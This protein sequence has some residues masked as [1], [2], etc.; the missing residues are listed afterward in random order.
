MI[1]GCSESQMLGTA[2]NTTYCIGRH[3]HGL[4]QAS[5][6]PRTGCAAHAPFGTAHHSRTFAACRLT[7]N[8]N[9]SMR[10]GCRGKSGQGWPFWSPQLGAI[11][12]N[13]DSGN[14]AIRDDRTVNRQ[15]RDGRSGLHNLGALPANAIRERRDQRR[16]Q[17]RR[18]N[19]VA[20][21]GTLPPRRQDFAAPNTPEPE[22]S[23]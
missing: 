2:G 7:G 10:R 16:S 11:Q 4:N 12:T 14:A 9:H 13:G 20:G 1:G 5:R 6:M 23:A 18:R 3:P 19:S 15:A 22:G 17:K 21:G 8:A